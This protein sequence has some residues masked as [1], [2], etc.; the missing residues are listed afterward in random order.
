[1]RVRNEA[2]VKGKHLKLGEDRSG[3]SMESL[4]GASVI[5]GLFYWYKGDLL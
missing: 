1:M 5:H 4:G 2:F 3:E